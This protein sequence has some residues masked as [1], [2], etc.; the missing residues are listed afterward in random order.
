MAKAAGSRRAPPRASVGGAAALIV[1]LLVAALFLFLFNPIPPRSA[2]DVSSVAQTTAG[3]EEPNFVQSPSTAPQPSPTTLEPSPI[4]TA[5]AAP[6][7]AAP[8]EAAPLPPPPDGAPGAPCAPAGLGIPQMGVKAPVVRVGLD[9]D[10]NLA[11]PSDADKKKAGYYANGVLAGSSRGS[12]IMDGHTYRDG[13]AI[14]Q[15]DFDSKARVGMTVELS[16]QLGG[17]FTYRVGE[18]KLDLNV[19]DYSRFVDAR[20]LYAPDGPPQI[21]LITCTDWN[22]INRTYDHRA[23]LIA[24]PT[25]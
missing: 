21:V 19:S 1:L 4:D 24:T 23:I 2:A 11:A 18:V 12:I 3:S 20:R 15:T 13:T 25:S 9:A 16:C 6:P 22:A 8:A 17:S 14:F 5:T 7:P 10:G